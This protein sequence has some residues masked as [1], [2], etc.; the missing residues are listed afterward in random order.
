MPF[1]TRISSFVGEQPRLSA[2]LLAANAAQL[3]ENV[4]LTAGR[5]DPR[6][7]PAQLAP[8]G[9]PMAKTIYRMFSGASDY[10]LSWAADVDVA[11]T[12]LAAD[13][14]FRIGFTSG[15]FEPRTTNLPMATAGATFP[16]QWFVLG[17][18]PP[19]TKATVSVAGGSGTSTEDRYYINTFVTPWGE[20]SAPSPP[21]VVATGFANGSW[22]VSGMDPAP[23]NSGTLSAATYLA[24]SVTVTM[25]SVFGL[26]AGEYITF[27]SVLGMT[28]LNRSL[29]ITSVDYTLKKVT[30]S[31][32][33]AQVYTSGGTWNRDAPHNTLGMTRRIYRTAVGS[34]G[35]A[36]MFVAEVPVATVSYVDNVSAVN[37][38][39]PCPSVNWLMPP[40]DLR[41]LATLPNGS[42]VGFSGN[43]LCFSDPYHMFA[44]PLANQ[45]ATDFPIVG[46]G[47]FGQSVVVGTT[48]SPYIATGVDPSA[49]TL[50]R[51]PQ[52]WPCVSKTGMVSVNGA[53]Y[54]PTNMGLAA[55]GIQGAT[56]MTDTMF[57]QR[58][59]VALSPETFVAAQHD[60]QYFAA[61]T[62]AG[63]TKV[64]TIA[65]ATGVTRM[66]VA[67]TALYSDA[68]NGKLYGALGSTVYDMVPVSGSRLPMAWVSKEFVV[69]TPINI[70][71]VQV[72]AVYAASAA[73]R[74]AQQQANAAIATANAA[75]Y[76]AGLK[77]AAGLA[78]LNT[79]PVNNDPRLPSVLADSLT[80]S[81]FVDGANV[82]STRVTGPQ[83]FRLPSLPKYDSFYFMLSGDL[84][85]ADVVIGESVEAL[86]GV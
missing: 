41:G 76:A 64:L 70:S 35:T 17:V 55:V 56:L 19:T 22:T 8:I 49:M 44:W 2:R 20:E 82:F 33:T 67:P 51:V 75:A 21:S 31:L 54:Y 4:T 6:Y 46:L 9:T 36:F 13:P 18:T 66:A 28:D 43:E 37:L 45:L 34:S 62:V 80:F 25:S 38:G 81:M 7:T 59:W 63:V 12:P 57:A 42:V 5:L 72:N 10:W 60:G 69:P 78:A 14:S 86:K 71:A 30:V 48:G 77:N 39:E 29:K 61:Y 24:G 23:L 73:Q 16:T 53:V 85:V 47:A 58:D 27:G 52:P 40:A 79:V 15:V 26:R 3:A 83:V 68:T 1:A 50:E 11:K 74:L 84:Q 65:A 32:T